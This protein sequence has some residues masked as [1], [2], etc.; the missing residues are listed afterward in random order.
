[1]PNAFTAVPVTPEKRYTASATVPGNGQQRDSQD[2]ILPGW[3]AL[4]T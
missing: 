1:M 2:S 3:I 4:A